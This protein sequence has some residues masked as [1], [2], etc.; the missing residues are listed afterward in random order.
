M[1]FWESVIE[2]VMYDMLYEETK[3][4]LKEIWVHLD[5][6]KFSCDDFDQVII[7]LMSSWI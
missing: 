1:S 3:F 7:A 4:D 2:M 6:L 5:T